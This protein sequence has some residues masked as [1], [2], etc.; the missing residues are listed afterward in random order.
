MG[1]EEDIWGKSIPGRG[2]RQHRGCEVGMP[3]MFTEEQGGQG[4]WR[5]SKGRVV[6]MRPRKQGEGRTGTCRLV[7]QFGSSF[8]RNGDLLENFDQR[9]T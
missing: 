9:M 6:D 1:N 2:N 8:E 3:G 4:G 5:G 7:W